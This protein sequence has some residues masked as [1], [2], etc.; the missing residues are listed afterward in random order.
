M[1]VR[2]PTELG[3]II[4][5]SR[6]AAGMT[7]QALAHALQASRKWVSDV[8]SGKPTS[9]IGRILGAMTLLGIGLSVHPPG[10]PATSAQSSPT[11]PELPDLDVVRAAYRAPP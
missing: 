7:Q 4:R 11:D 2:T 8:E 10:A 3:Q 5:A 9:E 1:H 6:V